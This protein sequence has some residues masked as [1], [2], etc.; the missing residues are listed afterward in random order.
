MFSVSAHGSR[1]GV[2]KKIQGEKPANPDQAA[3]SKPQLAARYKE[4]CAQAE[5]LKKILIDEIN[6]LGSELNGVR[7]QAD[8]DF[9][10]ASRTLTFNVVGQLFHL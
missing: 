3:L 1:E 6:S 2:I 7:V 5:R 9:N 8:C 10:N 4:E